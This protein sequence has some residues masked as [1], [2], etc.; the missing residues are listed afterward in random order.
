MRRIIIFLS[1]L[2]M[3]ASCGKRN[4]TPAGLLKPAKMQDVLWDI[5]RL[6]AFTSQFIKPKPS[7]NAVEENASLQKQVFAI[8]QVSK[9]D[10]YRS[11]DYYKT[12][13]DLMKIILDSIV[14]KAGREKFISINP[15]CL[16]QKNKK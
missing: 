8:H 14:S 3:L 12:H 10:F 1:M 16:K 2:L 15:Q 13:A 9:E 4:D 7:L 11:F 6:E 5:I